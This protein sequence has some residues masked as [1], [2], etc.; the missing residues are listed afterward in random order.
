MIR[1]VAGQHNGPAEGAKK[2]ERKAG[3]G[4]AGMEADVE[5]ATDAPVIGQDVKAS[6]ERMRL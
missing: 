1:A 5:V 2:R 3:V 6:D 4:S